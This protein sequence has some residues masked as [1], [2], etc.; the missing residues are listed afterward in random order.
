MRREGQGQGPD[1]VTR[2]TMG[3]GHRTA[4]A[5]LGVHATHSKDS[6][7]KTDD[8]TRRTM[9]PGHRTGPACLGVHATHPKDSP[10]KTPP[11]P[12]AG[13]QH[14]KHAPLPATRS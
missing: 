8:V 12:N 7:L 14:A 5:R 2:R 13:G 9:G 11:W 10:L 1:D 3:P 6:P 4:P